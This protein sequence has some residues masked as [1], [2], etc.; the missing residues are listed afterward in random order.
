M[1]TTVKIFLL[2]SLLGYVA[3]SDMFDY[4]TYVV[5]FKG[6]HKN[7]HQ[8]SL[9]SI[10]GQEA[11]DTIRI[12]FTADTHR[13]YD[14][15]D[16]FVRAANRL[17]ENTPFDFV[18]H[19][20][21]MADFG[22]PQQYLWGNSYLLNL[23]V[24]YFVVVGN[25]DVVGNG[26]LAYSEMYGE[27]NFSFIYADIKFVFINT[28]SREYIFNGDVPDIDWLETQL[29]PDNDFAHAVVLFHVPPMDGDFDASLEESFSSTLAQYNNVMFTVHGHLHGHEFYFPYPDS[30][31]YVNVYGVQNNKFNVIAISN[32]KF[33]F[34]THSF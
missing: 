29:R 1:R 18:V 4:S 21:D 23:D 24:P 5:D 30:I 17:N 2:I 10:A 28:N 32:G 27:F 8:T 16:N 7:V 13:F 31:P 3:C 19:V 25:H 9:Q 14:E 12:A 33:E 15:F 34:E 6:E 11:D 20:G 22:L 26:G